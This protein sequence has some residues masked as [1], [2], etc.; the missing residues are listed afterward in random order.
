M[1]V[2]VWGGGREA[3]GT[4]GGAII[5]ADRKRTTNKKVWVEEGIKNKRKKKNAPERK[6][7]GKK[8]LYNTRRTWQE[9]ASL[10]H[11]LLNTAIIIH[12]PSL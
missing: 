12:L 2:C 7:H 6:N 5:R 8:E 10:R 9:M 11:R 1:C 3:L 4:V